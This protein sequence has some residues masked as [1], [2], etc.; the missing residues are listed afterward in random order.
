MNSQSRSLFSALSVVL[1]FCIFAVASAQQKD[2]AAPKNKIGLVKGKFTMKDGKPMVNGV[3]IFFDAET[4]PIPDVNKHWRVPDQVIPLNDNGEFSRQLPEGKYVIGMIKRSSNK[5]EAGPPR[6]GDFFYE[7]FDEKGNLKLLFIQGGKEEDLGT[8]QGEIPFKGANFN[9]DMLTG[10]EGKV[11][12]EQGAPVEGAMVFAFSSP[13]AIG[14]PLFVSDKTGKDGI[15]LLRLGAGGTYYLKV[16]SVYGGGT[17]A[18]GE[19][20]G[21]YGNESPQAV[22]VRKGEITRNIEINTTIFKRGPRDKKTN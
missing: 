1:F 5:L 16:R 4:G 18:E 13:Q 17:P 2:A 22:I 15:Y 8:I 14:K 12:S 9:K 7:R 20:M 21:F 10:I 6:P 19:L 3:V 11:L